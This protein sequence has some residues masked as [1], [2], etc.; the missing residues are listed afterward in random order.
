MNIVDL[1]YPTSVLYGNKIFVSGVKEENGETSQVFA[2]LNLGILHRKMF[3]TFKEIYTWKK[4]PKP[5]ENLRSWCYFARM[6][7]HQGKVYLTGKFS[8]PS[9]SKMI[10]KSFDISKSYFDMD[11]N[12]F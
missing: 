7:E 4:L 11:R 5:D 10:L 1:L 6:Q 12:N 9:G 8:F 2:S 3:L